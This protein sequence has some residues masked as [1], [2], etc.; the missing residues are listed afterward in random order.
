M[1]IKTART[2]LDCFDDEV[3][4]SVS[5]LELGPSEREQLLLHDTAYHP[6]KE[7]GDR[8]LSQPVDKSEL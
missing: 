1:G 7:T 5:G 3:V 2:S 8:P 6:L 4:D